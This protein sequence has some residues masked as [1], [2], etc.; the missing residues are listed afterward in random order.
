ME[1]TENLIDVPFAYRH[2]CWFCGEPFNGHFEFPQQAHIVLSCPHPPVAVPS[3]IECKTIAKTANAETIWQVSTMVKRALMNVY[4]KDLAI[5]LNWTQEELANSQFEGGN[6]AGFQR[7]A[8]FM[9]EVAKAR[10]NYLGWPLSLNGIQLE[11]TNEKDTFVFDGIL[12]PSVG[13][14]IDQYAQAYDLN[15]IFFKEVLAIMSENNFAQAV[16]FCR[17]AVGFTPQ[18]RKVALQTLRNEYSA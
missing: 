15:M 18:E 11:I 9:Y 6:F 3:C 17:I 13:D 10:V 16:R 2:K 12:Y 7:S 1:T 5:G 4:Q 14:A 8:W